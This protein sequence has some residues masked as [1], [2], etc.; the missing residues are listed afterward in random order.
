MPNYATSSGRPLN[1]TKDGRFKSGGGR[2]YA[3]PVQD[4]FAH[5]PKVLTA[6]T[7]GASVSAQLL[8]ALKARGD[9]LKPRT[10]VVKQA[11]SGGEQFVDLDISSFTSSYR[12]FWMGELAHDIKAS[13][14]VRLG[15]ASGSDAEKAVR[16][17]SLRLAS[18]SLQGSDSHCALSRSPGRDVLR[19]ARR[20]EARG[21]S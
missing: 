3:V 5:A 16:L 1:E 13:G 11:T 12:N 8:E 15:P 7:T 4:G 20:E 18:S 10:G 6:P 9:V 19:N 14:C 17:T 2:T 21:W